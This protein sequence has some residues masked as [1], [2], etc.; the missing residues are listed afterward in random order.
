M[1]LSRYFP[2]FAKYS[3]SPTLKWPLFFI[4]PLVPFALFF[5]NFYQNQQRLAL[6]ETQIE[7]LHL[8]ATAAKKQKDKEGLFFHQIQ[9]AEPDFLE[10][11]LCSIP[12]LETEI[13]KLRS[14][15]EESPDQELKQRLDALEEKGNKLS[16]IEQNKRTFENLQESEMVQ[17]TPVEMNEEDLKKILSAIEGIS[18]QNGN[19]PAGKPVLLIKDFQL[20]KT[21]L[22]EDESAFS[23][24]LNLIK[25]E[26]QKNHKDD[27]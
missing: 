13:K 23:V 5:I 20:S 22:H 25:R 12:F 4:L 16:F 3:I 27:S 18:M 26:N 6:V 15:S 21:K 2:S 7:E 19:P 24:K 10:K 17:K 14:F 11:H 8:K 9:N 1:N